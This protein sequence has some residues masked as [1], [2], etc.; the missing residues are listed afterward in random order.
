MDQIIELERQ[1]E[2]LQLK[3]INLKA[4]VKI[5]ELEKKLLEALVDLD[6]YK[7]RVIAISRKEQIKNRGA[8]CEALN[9]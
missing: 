8:E 7:N 4:R 6:K 5:E 9:N 2:F 1:Q 3:I